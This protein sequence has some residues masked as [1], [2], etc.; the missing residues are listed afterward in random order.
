MS[1]QAAYIQKGNNVVYTAGADIAYG[2]VVP[3]TGGIGVAGE[4]I[5]NG[6]AGTIVIDGVFEMTAINT[7][8]FTAGQQVFWDD[9]ANKLTNVGAGNTP[10]GMCVAAKAETGTTALVLINAGGVAVQAAQADSTASTVA[11][12]VVDLNALL[13]KL[14][15]AGI[16]ANA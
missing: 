4:A 7:A 2:D 8:A 1:K 6:T 5:A 12:A 14:R 3:L 13:A 10:A 11:A 9:S 15:N 16:I